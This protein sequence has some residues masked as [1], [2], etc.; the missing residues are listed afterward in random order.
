MALTVGEAMIRAPK[1]LPANASVADARRLFDRP[2]IRTVLLTEGEAFAGAI[3]RDR[4]PADAPDSTPAREYVEPEPVT[5]T[6]GMPMSEAVKLLEA[7]EE[8]RLVVL[9][10]DGIR[11]AGLLCVNAS[12]T[13]FCM[14]A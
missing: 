12:A 9:G 5:A 2:N 3:E 8:P 11:L 6:P 14:Q 13:G 4:L 1:T 7:R 10:E